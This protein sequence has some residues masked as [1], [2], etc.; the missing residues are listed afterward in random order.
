M[1]RFFAFKQFSAEDHCTLVHKVALPLFNEPG[2]Y[3]STGSL[4][5][6]LNGR[7]DRK[8]FFTLH[9]KTAKLHGVK[10]HSPTHKYWYHGEEWDEFVA[11]YGRPLFARDKDLPVVAHASIWDFY[12]HIGFDYKTGKYTK[13]KD[14]KLAKK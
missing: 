2:F 9:P 7:T 3:R 6:F 13:T 4:N 12:T 10:T 11:A 1:P 14:L 5:A 8:N